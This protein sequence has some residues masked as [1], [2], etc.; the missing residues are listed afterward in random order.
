M[1]KLARCPSCGGTRFKEEQEAFIYWGCT[2]DTEGRVASY[3][4]NPIEYGDGEVRG[5]E[6]RGCGHLFDSSYDLTT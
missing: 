4:K 2:I 5:Y 6:C 1:T 3:T